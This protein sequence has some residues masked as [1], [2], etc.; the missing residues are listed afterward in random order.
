MN[1]G[2]VKAMNRKQMLNVLKTI[3]DIAEGEINKNDV[4]ITPVNDGNVSKSNIEQIAGT[5]GSRNFNKSE[6]RVIKAS[7]NEEL[8]EGVIYFVASQADVEDSEGDII[9]LPELTKAAHDYIQ[10]SRM[11]DINHDW[12]DAGTVVESVIFDETMV[13][14]IQEGVIEKGAWVV[15]IKP[16]DIEMARMAL[17]GELTGASIGGFANRKGVA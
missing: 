10:E 7:V 6:L 16:K 8:G 12:K 11:A 9:P 17:R 1:N 13:K 15:G 14:A 5:A 3:C 2:Q 4:G